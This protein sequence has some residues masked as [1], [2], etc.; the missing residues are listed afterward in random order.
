MKRFAAKA[1]LLVVS[2][3][4][5]LGLSELIL[6]VVYPQQL[7]VWYSLRNG[8]VI[9]PPGTR[10]HLAS[11][12]QT[13]EFNSLGMR[14]VEHRPVKEPGTFRI[15]VLGDSFMEALQV[16]LEES[17]HRLL[18]HRLRSLT[19]RPVEVVNG[20]VSGW[21]TDDHLEYLTRYG[22]KLVPDLVLDAM[23]L[24]NDV[25]D[26]L[27]QR[28]HTLVDGRLVARP[29]AEMS[30]ADFRLLKVKDY[31][32][33]RSHLTQLMR[34]YRHLS[35]MRQAGRQLDVHVLRLLEKDESASMRKGWELTQ[36]LMLGLRDEGA[37]ISARTAVMLIP[38]SLQI[39][40]D[41]R[42]RWL[43]ANG[44]A[45]DRLDLERPQDRMRAIGA[46]LT[47]ETVDLLPAFRK[48]FKDN[49]RSL[50]LVGD[51]HWTPE[52]HRLA[53]AVVADQLVARKLL[54]GATAAGR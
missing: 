36:G 39:Y 24:H 40:G 2:T 45:A 33:S 31:F 26:N 23:T 35:G 46:A 53:A 42:Q 27:E 47:V 11:F 10:I 38:L 52:G 12:G 16:P 17:F 30:E 19:G 37:R 18:E 9:H 51:G 32:A 25:S 6:R 21:G 15:L 13:V 34:K 5:A 49:G 50:H 44:V 48:S 1:L 4:C 28:Y 7:G 43:E 20:A 54:V 29:P 8:M 14:D 41:V 3:V 22:V